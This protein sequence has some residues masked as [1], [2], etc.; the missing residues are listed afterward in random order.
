MSFLERKYGL[1]IVLRESEETDKELAK[2]Q[3]IKGN[4][5]GAS[6]RIYK[7]TEY[8]EEGSPI[9]FKAVV[10]SGNCGKWLTD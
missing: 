2:K 4:V 8:Q 5:L 3:S 10:R 1:G 6:L 7:V 9:E